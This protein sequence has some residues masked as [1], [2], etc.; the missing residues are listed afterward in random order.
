MQAVITTIQ[1]ILNLI[2]PVLVSFGILV[3][4]WGVV[5]YV[6]ADDEEAKKNGKN[7]IIYGI[8]A[9]V[10]ITGLWGLVSVVA[11]TFGL[12][13]GS[14]QSAASGTCNVGSDFRGIVDYVICVIN[15]SIIPL[16]FSLA[17]LV[18]VFGIVKFFIIEANEEAKRT[19]GKQFMIWSIIAFTVM[20]SVWGL[21]RIFGS[22][23]NTNT[24]VIPQLK[25]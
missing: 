16:I 2:V 9:F 24:T 15:K 6:I 11:K 12:N 18:F 1:N 14:I 17:L 20:L 7:R 10:V 3:F 25:E 8:L 13:S 23:L 5:Q 22:V 19:Q 21:V 4:V